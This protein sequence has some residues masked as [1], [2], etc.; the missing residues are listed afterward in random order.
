MPAGSAHLRV[1]TN[2]AAACLLFAATAACR[3]HHAGLAPPNIGVD[4]AT[5]GWVDL[6]PGMALE[7]D[8]A[9]Y[10]EGS[11]RRSFADYLGDEIAKYE[12]AANGSLRL[13]SLSSL[14]VGKQPPRD[15]P[16][17]QSFIGRRNASSRYHRLFFRV[18]FSQTGMP[19][20]AIL[21]GARSNAELDQITSQL[22]DGRNSAC[23]A[24]CNV[25]PEWTTAS[26]M[27]AVMVNGIPRRVLWGSTIGTVALH[28]VRITL[29]RNDSGRLTS[30]P[31]LASDPEA[32]RLPLQH[33]DR[34]TWN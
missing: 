2:L 13:K 15:Q 31:V 16:A 29:L 3:T 9:Y 12:V 33:G 10:R 11:P 30:I 19:R 34:I 14:P 24:R 18:V 26:A 20:Q 22:S 8:G 1:W 5:P 23:G 28:P 21:V 6:R 32:L 25:L 17:I 4:H 7:I 27:I